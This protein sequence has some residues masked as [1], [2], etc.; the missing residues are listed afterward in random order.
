M[1]NK[2]LS[3]YLLW[4]HRFQRPDFTLVSFGIVV[5][6]PSIEDGVDGGLFSFNLFFWFWWWFPETYLM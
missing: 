3:L 4:R 5:G 1:M 2:R 6:L